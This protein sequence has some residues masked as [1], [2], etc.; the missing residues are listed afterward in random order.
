MVLRAAGS[1]TALLISTLIVSWTSLAQI[2]IRIRTRI[3]TRT[4]WI[5]YLGLSGQGPIATPVHPKDHES[6]RWWAVFS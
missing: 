3:R 5:Y 6:R 4:V 1:F 2:R